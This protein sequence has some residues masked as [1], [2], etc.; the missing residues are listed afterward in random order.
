MR[1]DGGANRE[2]VEALLERAERETLAD[3]G[4]PRWIVNRLRER[5][6]H[7]HMGYSHMGLLGCH[8]HRADSA[9]IG[10]ATRAH[11]RRRGIQAVIPERADQIRSRRKRPPS[12]RRPAFDAQ[13]YKDRN[14][15]ERAINRLKQ[16]R[17]V[18]T[19]YDKR[20]F[21]WR[22]TVDVACIRIWLRSPVHT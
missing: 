5:D 17:A 22:G 11:L 16:Y 20:D 10:K 18:A 7:Q 13:A 14:V 6:A 21:V 12:G 3:P 1:L 4:L 9:A 19:R 8:R 2:A 15:V